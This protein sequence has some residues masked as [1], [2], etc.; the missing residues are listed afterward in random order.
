MASIYDVSFTGSTGTKFYISPTLPNIPQT[1]TDK[2]G[3]EIF[4]EFDEG[5]GGNSPF[6]EVFNIVDG[7]AIGGNI[8][9]ANAATLRD[10]KM[11]KWLGPEDPGS[12]AITL[13]YAAAD[14]GQKLVK[15]T[16]RKRAMAAFKV[17]TPDG[18]TFYFGGYVTGVPKNVGSSSDYLSSSFNIEVNVKI[19]DS[20]MLED[21]A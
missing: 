3:Y 19:F 10:G 5:V 4:A 7:G 16:K 1:A 15:A 21:A 2:E 12:M 18:E 11:Q 9:V 8:E 6:V 13:G 17:E 14:P 20:S